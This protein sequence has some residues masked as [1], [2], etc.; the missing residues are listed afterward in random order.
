MYSFDF[1]NIQTIR[2]SAFWRLLH[3]TRHL[4]RIVPPVSPRQQCWVQLTAIHLL[5]VCYAV[6]VLVFA[7]WFAFPQCCSLGFPFSHNFRADWN[8]CVACNWMFICMHVLGVSLHRLL[9]HVH[10]YFYRCQRGVLHL[11]IYGFRWR[12]IQSWPPWLLPVFASDCSGLIDICVRCAANKAL[13]IRLPVWMPASNR[14]PWHHKLIM[15]SLK[16]FRSWA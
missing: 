9:G 8:V 3:L 14:P 13:F 2:Q 12:L 11:H 15:S 5:C 1:Q 16:T 10:H 4:C 6:S 7:P